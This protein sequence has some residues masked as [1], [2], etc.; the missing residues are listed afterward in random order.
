MSQDNQQVVKILKEQK[1]EALE[2]LTDIESF[3]LNIKHLN[4]KKDWLKKLRQKRIDDIKVETDKIQ[5]QI[6]L[7]QETIT[8][9]LKDHKTKTLNFPGVAKVSS[10][11]KKGKWVIED[12]AD[13]I[14]KM[15]KSLDDVDK[16]KCIRVKKSFNKTELNKVLENWLETGRQIPDSIKKEQDSVSLSIKYDKEA[17]VQVQEDLDDSLDDNSGSV[18]MDDLDTLD[19]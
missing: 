16:D 4:D 19:F 13:A 12:E 10:R 5:Q 11:T 6:D 14:E 8:L 17:D 7:L 18:E 2:D 3:V 9:T 15:E 1:P